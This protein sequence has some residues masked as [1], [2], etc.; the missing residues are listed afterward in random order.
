VRAPAIQIIELV[1]GFGKERVRVAIAAVG[2][3][4][5]VDIR[6]A[7]LLTK[8]SGHWYPTAKGV[9]IG[10][11]AVPALIKALK[12]AEAEAKAGDFPE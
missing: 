10:V 7:T 2:D 1:D 11:R 12:R 8:T 3:D 4:W 5:V 9:R 6:A